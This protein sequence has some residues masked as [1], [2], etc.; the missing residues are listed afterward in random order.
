MR[1]HAAFETAAPVVE[2]GDRRVVSLQIVGGDEGLPRPLLKFSG[3][4][5]DIL[6]DVLR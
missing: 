3:G 6:R 2:H 1:P 4:S 5:I